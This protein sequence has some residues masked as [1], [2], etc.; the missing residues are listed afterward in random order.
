MTNAI[1]FYV[2][3][4]V[5]ISIYIFHWGEI[6]RPKRKFGISLF[7]FFGALLV[8][9]FI[10]QFLLGMD[11]MD[12]PANLFQTLMI[13]GLVFVMYYGGIKER[14]KLIAAVAVIS[15]IDEMSCLAISYVFFGASPQELYKPT[16]MLSVIMGISNDIMLISSICSIIILRRKDERYRRMRAYLLLM[17]AFAFIHMAFFIF[18]YKTG[19]DKLENSDILVQLVFQSMLVYLLIFLYYTMKKNLKRLETEEML[20]QIDESMQ[21]T[22]EYYTLARSQYDEISRIRHDMNNHLG[23]AAALIKD[24]Q[25]SEAQEIIEKL[26]TS[27]DG[28]KAVQY[29]ENPV[30]NTILT[31]KANQS[32][33]K[34]ID[35]QFMLKDC[36]KIPCDSAELCSLL[37]NL[38]DN[39]ARAALES[40]GD[41]VLQIESGIVNEF[42]IL[43]VTNTAKEGTVSAGT[44]TPTGKK[45]SGHGYGMKIIK[46]IAEK[47]G[48][49]FT[50]EQE[51][52]FVIGTVTLR[53]K[54]I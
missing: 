47:Y 53:H 24:N 15:F 33:Y 22:H 2:F 31:T 49:S 13:C 9:N 27:L 52:E 45:T 32:E 18:Y 8:H 39:A 11:R 21:R 40:G 37:S 17:T 16:E 25:Q 48:G 28:I 19:Q 51:G 38:F 1:M 46:M 35:M 7:V 41:P 23:T 4:F 44:Q 34:N 36:D 14:L 54:Q 50:L 43:K 6:G 30:I 26:R 10:F 20:A 42:F 12:F 3:T 5:Q 29:C